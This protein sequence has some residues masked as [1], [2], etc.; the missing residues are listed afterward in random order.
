MPQLN[1]DYDYLAN[2]ESHRKY[3]NSKRKVARESSRYNYA[4]AERE[5]RRT[6]DRTREQLRMFMMDGDSAVLPS[7]MMQR[8]M[9][10]I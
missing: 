10:V 4:Y 9:K 8:S 5:Y 7:S 6:S 3:N 1:Y 2:Y